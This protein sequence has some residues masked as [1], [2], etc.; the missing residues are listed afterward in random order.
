VLSGEPLDLSPRDGEQLTDAVRAFHRTGVNPYL[1]DAEATREG[2]RLYLLHCAFCHGRAG[3][4]GAAPPL[5]GPDWT[6]TI[7]EA[8]PGLFSVIWGGA[9]GAMTGFQRRGVPQDHILRIM[10][11]IR[12]L[13]G[14]PA[15]PPGVPRRDDPFS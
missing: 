1:N 5:I 10:A 15:P 11:Y 14:G 7:A 8:D 6:Y 3:G 4:G 13:S 12:T 2:Q 9:F